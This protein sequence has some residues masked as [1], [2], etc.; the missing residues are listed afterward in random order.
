MR[1]LRLPRRDVRRQHQRRQRERA[2]RLLHAAGIASAEQSLG[3]DAQK[4]D[5]D[6]ADAANGEQHLASSR[7]GRWRSRSAAYIQEVVR[8][9]G[10]G[11]AEELLRV[12]QASLPQR[13]PSGTRT[14]HGK[15]EVAL[16]VDRRP[17]RR[18]DGDAVQ[19]GAIL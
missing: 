8:S 18:A 7:S 1:L 16:N 13:G 12:S 14:R 6:G 10:R 3:S 11:V 17:D 2:Q 5:I 19:I 4:R 15:S 9:E